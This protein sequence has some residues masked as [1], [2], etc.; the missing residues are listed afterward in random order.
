MRAYG[1][2]DWSGNAGGKFAF[3]SSAYLAMALVLSD[4]G[5]ALRRILME[6]MDYPDR[7]QLICD[8][9]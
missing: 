3:G 1:F 9:C 5:D 2:I 4:D 8:C 7:K 6:G